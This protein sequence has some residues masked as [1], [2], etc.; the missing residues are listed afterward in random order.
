M[1]DKVWLARPGK[2]GAVVYVCKTAAD[3]ADW[4]RFDDAFAS[5]TTEEAR[6]DALFSRIAVEERSGHVPPRTPADVTSVAAEVV[7]VRAETGISGFVP[8]R[9]VQLTAARP[10]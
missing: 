2:P 1:G 9:F 7:E 8:A 10:K 3:A 6:G 5:A 4:S